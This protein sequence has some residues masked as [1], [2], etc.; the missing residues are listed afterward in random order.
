MPGLEQHLVTSFVAG[1]WLTGQLAP[2]TQIKPFHCIFAAEQHFVASL[3]AAAWGGG[4]IHFWLVVSHPVMGD[5]HATQPPV[6]VLQ[7]SPEAQHFVGSSAVG[8]WPE[9]QED[10]HCVPFH[11]MFA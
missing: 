5:W 6:F 2:V 7:C 4:Q 3:V 8:T 1:Y 10:A 9:G 11:V